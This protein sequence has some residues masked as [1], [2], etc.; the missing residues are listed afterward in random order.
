MRELFS[1][2][3]MDLLIAGLKL[4]KADLEAKNRKSRRNLT[5]RSMDIISEREFQIEQLERMVQ[6]IYGEMS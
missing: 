1:E 6:D 5:T 4:K 3:E 2:E